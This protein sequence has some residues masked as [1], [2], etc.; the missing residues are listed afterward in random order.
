MAGHTED[1]KQKRANKLNKP[2]A[3]EAKIIGKAP[4]KEGLQEAAQDA[5]IEILSADLKKA[6]EEGA[7]S[8]AMKSKKEKG[9]KINI[10]KKDMYGSMGLGGMMKMK[11]KGM[12]MGDDDSLMLIIKRMAKGGKLPMAEKGMMMKALLEDPKQM[13]IAK[14]IIAKAEE[15]MKIDG[16]PKK[17]LMFE[18]E[19][20]KVFDGLDTSMDK[21]RVAEV[22]KEN[23]MKSNQLLDKVSSSF[24]SLS[25]KD[26]K[27]EVGKNLKKIMSVLADSKRGQ[28]KDFDDVFQKASG[29]FYKS[30]V[31]PKMI[32]DYLQSI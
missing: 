19:I 8:G 29:E 13:A 21:E 9:G 26:R 12:K 15:G 24:K 17:G 7:F 6:I 2:L 31:T 10:M 25:T 1:E 5:V 27:G 30:N 23:V 20:I 3:K 28:A 16:G 11:K 14:K 18:E 4:M 22:R 32:E